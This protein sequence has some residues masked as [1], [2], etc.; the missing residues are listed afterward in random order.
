MSD[1]EPVPADLWRNPDQGN[2]IVA[3]T[4]PIG[5]YEIERAGERVSYEGN[6][7]DAEPYQYWGDRA[8]KAGEPVA[9]VN[10]K[11]GRPRKKA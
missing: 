3:G 8:D 7:P 6:L 4:I 9:P 11:R 10:R 2:R 1:I 5:D